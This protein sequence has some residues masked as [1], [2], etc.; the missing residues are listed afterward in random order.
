MIKKFFFQKQFPI[1]K[2]T[3]FT[4]LGMF[5]YND[6]NGIMTAE[7]NNWFEWSQ[8]INYLNVISNTDNYGQINN[9]KLGNR[10]TEKQRNREIENRETEKQKTENRKQRNREIEKQRNRER[11]KQRNRETRKIEI[12]KNRKTDVL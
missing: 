9:M 3:L 7:V 4:F 11:E 1:L 6:L 8:I 2:K 10:E 5:E 12:Q